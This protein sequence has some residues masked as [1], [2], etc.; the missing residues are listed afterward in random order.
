MWL[1]GQPVFDTILMGGYLT[2]MTLMWG[3]LLLGVS[4][5]A[6]LH[7][8]VRPMGPVTA[9]VPRVSVCI[10]A[11]DEAGNIGSCVRAV[12]AQ[13]WPNLEVIV[14]DDRSTDQTGAIAREAMEGDSRHTGPTRS[15]IW[16]S[17]GS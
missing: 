4:R 17:S 7:R 15:A 11:R 16:S 13:N 2:L 3:G 5:W 9:D 14:V 12:L 8:L 6:K 10:P 1:W